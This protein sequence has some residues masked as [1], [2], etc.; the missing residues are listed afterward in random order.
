VKEKHASPLPSPPGAAGGVPRLHREGDHWAVAWAG[1][2]VHLRHA[3]GV[4]D[5]ASLLAAPGRAFHVLDLL[6]A[7]GDGGSD[8]VLDRRARDAYRARAEEL[9]EEL[10]QTQRDHD[11][12]RA[13]R[14]RVELEAI[15]DEL[16]AAVGLGGR[17]RR[18]GDPAERARKTVSWRLRST[19]DRIERAHPALGRHLRQS[20]RMGTFCSYEPDPPVRWDVG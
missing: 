15:A 1:R 16:S 7:P 3:K 11:P 18:L 10:D 6:G 2:S 17:A 14:A 12:E 8:E 5:L 9:R 20:L 13:A 19:L 4:D